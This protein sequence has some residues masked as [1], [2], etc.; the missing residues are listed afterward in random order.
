MVRARQPARPWEVVHVAWADLV[1]VAD[2]KR[3]R[4][5]LP[6]PGGKLHH[7]DVWQP[8]LVEDAPQLVH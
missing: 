6:Q 3:S 5:Q 8:V 4:I 7:F 1:A 2:S